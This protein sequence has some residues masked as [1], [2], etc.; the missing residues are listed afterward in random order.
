M[1]ST[2]KFSSFIPFIHSHFFLYI[3]IYFYFILFIFFFESRLVA[4]PLLLRTPAALLT[5]PLE[6]TNALPT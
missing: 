2:S 4:F 6:I 5:C 3:Y 1:P